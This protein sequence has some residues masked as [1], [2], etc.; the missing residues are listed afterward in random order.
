M[1]DPN[2]KIEKVRYTQVNHYLKKNDN[3]ILKLSKY[4]LAIINKGHSQMLYNIHCHLM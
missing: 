1:F 4:L 3:I 2:I